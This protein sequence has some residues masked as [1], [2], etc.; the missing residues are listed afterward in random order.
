M[1]WLVGVT[2]FFLGLWPPPA[3]QNITR[4]QTELPAK[5]SAGNQTSMEKAIAGTQAWTRV[6]PWEVT[7][8]TGYSIGASGVATP[9]LHAALVQKGEYE[10]ILLPD[11]PFPHKRKEDLEGARSRSVDRFDYLP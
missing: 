1:L 7:A 6:K 3:R 10:A 8:E 9:L 4:S 5:P 2:D 11:N